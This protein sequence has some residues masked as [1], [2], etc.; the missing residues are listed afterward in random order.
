MDL[1]NFLI[2]SV[3]IETSDKIYCQNEDTKLWRAL[4]LI[5]LELCRGLKNIL[6][7]TVN[8]E[9][10]A[11]NVPSMIWIPIA[12]VQQQLTQYPSMNF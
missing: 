2:K 8:C 4:L 7:Y 9:S 5:A 11:W 6:G 3:A 12:H 1:W 10:G